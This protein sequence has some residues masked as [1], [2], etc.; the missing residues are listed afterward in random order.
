MIQDVVALHVMVS[1]SSPISVSTQLGALRR[2][3]SGEAHG[4]L[5]VQFRKVVEVKSLPILK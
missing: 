3:L 2:L 5:G 1:M 4:E